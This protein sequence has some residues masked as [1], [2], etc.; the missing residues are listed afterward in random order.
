MFV[1]MCDEQHNGM[2]DCYEQ[3]LKESEEKVELCAQ[4]D[5]LRERYNQV[6]QE[7]EADRERIPTVS[8]L[9]KI[10]KWLPLLKSLSY[11]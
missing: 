8:I 5:A 1:M 3:T 6:I 9:K 10:Q 7:R 11:N 4:I 2:M